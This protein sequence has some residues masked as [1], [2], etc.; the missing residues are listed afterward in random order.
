[1]RAVRARA[2]PI[3]LCA[4][5]VALAAAGDLLAGSQA[6]PPLAVVLPDDS[7]TRGDWTGLYGTHAYILCGMR[8]RHSLQGGKGWPIWFTVA[9][10]D[11]K[12]KAR[13]WWSSA[14]AA[15]D[16]SVLLEPDGT[17]RTQAV[18]DDHG[19]V[20]PLGKGPGFRLRL[21][22][23]EGRFL[24]SLYF[25]EV[26]WIQ[27]RGYSIRVLDD[28]ADG[29]SESAK[30]L[31]VETRV[32]DFLRGKYKRFAVLG[33]QKLLIAIDREMSPNAVLSGIFLDRLVS[34][35][36][37]LLDK[38]MA[39]RDSRDPAPASDPPPR[40]GEA[41]KGAEAALVNLRTS[42]GDPAQPER[43]LR[44]ERSAF[45][46][47]AKFAESRPSAYCP[48]LVGLW[49]RVEQRLE[50]A[51]AVLAGTPVS[52]D[53]LWL[54][55]YA[56]RARHDHGEAYHVTRQIAQSLLRQDASPPYASAKA[57]QLLRIYAESR[58]RSGRRPEA[59]VMLSA[60]S[61]FCLA[62]LPPELAKSKLVGF[63]KLA[64]QSGTTLPLARGLAAWSERHGELVATKERLLLA[65]L[66]YVAAQAEQ[67][68]PLFEAAEPQMEQGHQHRWLLVAMVSSLLQTDKVK[69]ATLL[70]K[71]LAATYPRTPEIE[72]AK[73]RLGVHYFNR[74][75]L[76]RAQE[77]FEDL[78]RTTKSDLYRH[79][80]FEYVDRISHMKTI[81]KESRAYK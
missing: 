32:E 66:Y 4:T 65:N 63:G 58:M 45:A 62:H 49:G 48:S 42:P 67:A 40:V 79:M 68:L 80:C 7:H 39:I 60:Y 6:K 28:S 81:S 77:C 47:L 25:F 13:G 78:L 38:T 46:A 31:L 75:Q 8:G 16:R 21:R 55:Y 71:R 34:P 17:T 30:P 19:E 24:L 37:A 23:P 76:D 72:E 41:T 61:E 12:E 29:A 73:Y 18:F 64:I 36:L 59:R 2:L 11:P 52:L 15:G 69:E 33:P 56:A 10:G 9:T 22:V 50:W 20:R 70:I 57:E 44:A 26:D 43:Y 1:M 3:G 14:P 27:Y 54:K 53:L 35:D 74:R 5:L 51:S